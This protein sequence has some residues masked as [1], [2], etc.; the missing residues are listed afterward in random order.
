DT[1]RQPPP[2]HLQTTGLSLKLPY[3][4]VYLMVTIE[5]SDQ[6][7][8]KEHVARIREY[9]KLA[10]DDLASVAADEPAQ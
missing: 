2:A 1:Q 9:L 4:G 7:L 5:A 10:E 8:T 3:K 6:Q